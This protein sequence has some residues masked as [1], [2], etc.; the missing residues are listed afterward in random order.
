M[1]GVSPRWRADFKR[2]SKHCLLGLPHSESLNSELVVLFMLVLLILPTFFSNFNSENVDGKMEDLDL[3]VDNLLRSS[4][5]STFS[6]SLTRALF[7]RMVEQV[8]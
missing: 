6:W 1:S 4:E 3:A 8:P 7:S 5:D 2:S